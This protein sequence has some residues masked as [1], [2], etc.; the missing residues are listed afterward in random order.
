MPRFKYVNRVMVTEGQYFAVVG[1]LGRSSL[2]FATHLDNS[3][4]SGMNG[5]KAP[6]D[7]SCAGGYEN[8]NKQQRF[9]KSFE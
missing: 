7:S 6:A 9:S 4:S 8:R 1:Y 2:E 5:R 3:F